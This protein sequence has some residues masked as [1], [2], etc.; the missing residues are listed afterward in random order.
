MVAPP[1][2][3][4]PARISDFMRLRESSGEPPAS[5]LSSLSPASGGAARTVKTSTL[6]E[7]SA[8]TTDWTQ[9]ARL[10]KAIVIGLGVLL[11]LGVGLMV[12]AIIDRAGDVVAE[13]P[14]GH[15]DAVVTL[16]P[17]SRVVAM[18]E[19][20]DH[21]S[22]LIEDAAGRQRVMTIDRRSGAV[23]GVLTL[24]SK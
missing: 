17:G 15:G 7:C 6:F 20:G 3:T 14:A 24:E 1:E 18:S 13:A 21:L 16:A 11:I 2:V 8:M 10:L 9:T 19:E 5:S 12:Y 22:L 4:W 23:I